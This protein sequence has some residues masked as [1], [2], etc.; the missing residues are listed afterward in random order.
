M[1]AR[2]D[3]LVKIPI[4]YHHETDKAY[5]VSHEKRPKIQIWVPKSKCELIEDGLEMHLEMTEMDAVKLELI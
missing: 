5:K 1:G 4:D 2:G 3:K